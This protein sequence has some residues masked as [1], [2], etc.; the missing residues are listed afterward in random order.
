MQQK[1]ATSMCINEPVIISHAPFSFCKNPNETKT[2]ATTAAAQIS[3]FIAARW[4]NNHCDIM[5]S[6]EF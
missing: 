4:Q 2:A 1:E 6:N 5:K 3:A